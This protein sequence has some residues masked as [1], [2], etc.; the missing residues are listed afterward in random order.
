MKLF[1]IIKQV[2]FSKF[3]LAG[4]SE[5]YRKVIREKFYG[6]YAQDYEDIL[7][8]KLLPMKNGFYLE[9][10]GYHPSRL[11]NTFRFYKKGW[12][13][14]VVE[15]NPEAK[16]LFENLRPADKFISKGIGVRSGKLD[17]FKYEIPALNT[18]DKQQVARN[19][20]NGYKVTKIVEVEI[21]EINKFL[22]KYIKQ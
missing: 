10:G 1:L 17:Y 5:V 12:R 6:S 9:I 4:I 20:T 22:T 2:G 3:V 7:M 19:K 8:E 21:F 11:S 16:K 14:V 13:G 15:P 18:F